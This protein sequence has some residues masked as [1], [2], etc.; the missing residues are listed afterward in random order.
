MEQFTFGQA[1]ALAGI[2]SS[3]SDFERDIKFLQWVGSRKYQ[4]ID[5]ITNQSSD[6][7]G[8]EVEILII[9]E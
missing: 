8:L 1:Q 5:P 9:K 6:S 3:D 2:D 4:I 7:V